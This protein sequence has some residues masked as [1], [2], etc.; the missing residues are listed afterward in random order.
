MHPLLAN[1]A[2]PLAELCRRYGVRR[3]ELFG[4]AAK[5]GFDPARSDLDFVAEFSDPSPTVEYA[6]RF[7]DFA[8]ALEVLLNRRIDLVS[9]NALRRSR[10]AAEIASSRQPVYVESDAVAV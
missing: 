4:S 8:A 6:D 9:A 1:Y 7:L 2:T 10:F 5:D 3:L